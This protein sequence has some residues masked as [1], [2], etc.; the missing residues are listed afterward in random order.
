MADIGIMG[1]TFDPV[2]NGHL[3]LARQA[4]EEYGLDSVW[5]M[6]SGQP[7]HKRDRQVTSKKDRCAMVKLAV[8]DEPG[9]VFSDFEVSREGRTY[10]ANT[11]AL[12]KEAYP[13]H[14]FHYIIGADSLYEIETWYHPELVLSAVPL[15]V[16]DRKYGPDHLP[17]ERQMAYLTGKYKADIR[18]IHWDGMDIASKDIRRL[19]ARGHS[20]RDFVPETVEEYIKSRHLYLS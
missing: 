8:K 17:L 13:S 1:G 7:P 9:F 10:T 12:L 14:V 6:P 16:A 19:A 20:I 3:S 4:Y 2:H 15:L 11:L 18:L 5:F